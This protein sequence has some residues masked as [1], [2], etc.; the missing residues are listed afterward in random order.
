[1]REGNKMD[2][3]YVLLPIFAIFVLGYVG[4]KKIGFDT[5]TISTMAMYLMTPVLVFRTFYITKFTS[6]HFYMFLYCFALCFLLIAVVSVFSTFKHYSISEKSGMILS[7][8]FMNNG[9][10]GTPVILLLFGMA[11][12]EYAVILMVAQSLVMCTIGVYFAAKGSSEGGGIK[13]A[14]KSVYKVPI[15]YGGIIGFIFQYLDIHLNKATMQAVDMVADASIP[16]VMIVLGM[17][18]AKISIKH[19]SFEKLSVS[20]LVKLAISPLLAYGLTLIL[21]LNHI[22]EQIMIITA[23]MPSAANTTMYALQFDTEPDFVSSA[24]LVS[25]VLSLIS[26]PIIFA[27]VL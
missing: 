7:S 9:N 8:V 6:E 10:Y 23:S 17:Q 26:L 2:F 21:P 13:Y 15:I 5:K 27:L 1:M 14:L 20:L 24:T 25:T 12:F 22:I 18:L 3:L 4:E 19:L 16:T 11:G